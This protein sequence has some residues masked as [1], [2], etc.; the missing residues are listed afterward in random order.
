MSNIEGF[1]ICP[2]IDSKLFYLLVFI[3]CSLM[4]NIIPRVFEPDFE[5]ENDYK[6][7][8]YFDIL[9]NFIGDF[10]AGIMIIVNKFRDNDNSNKL[11]TTQKLKTKKAMKKKFFFYLS[12]IAIID[13]LVQLC[14]S[15]FLFS[16]TI[17]KLMIEKNGQITIK[18]EDLY[19]V[20]LIDI[21]SRYFFS[22]LFLNS[23]FY[24]HHILSIIITCI[25]FIPLTIINIKDIF[26]GITSFKGI[27]LFQHIF[28]TI[29]YSLEDVLNK[30]CLN[31][32]ILRPYE[33]MFY[34][35]VFQIIII[36]PISI[37]AFLAIDQIDYEYFDT[38][39]I[40]YRLSFIIS[41]IFRTWSLITIIELINPNHLSVLKS[42]EFVV[43]FLAVLIFKKSRNKYNYYEINDLVYIFGAICCVISLIGSIIHNEIIIINKCGLLECTDYY[44]AE[45]KGFY[46]GDEDLEIDDQKKRINT[47]DSLLSSSCDE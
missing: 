18:E 20:V 7:K 38:K 17:P 28:M 14:L 25:G 8:S 2:K 35:A 39:F 9:S 46:G 19:F 45:I 43:L 10:L 40:I 6:L 41:N 21:I 23:Y 44:K 34:K 47:Q 37:Y 27:Y 31:Q 13:F 3:S 36:I 12:I 11:T 1:I 29:I 30:I 32:L 5:N 42:S 22:R 15:S 33:L 4:R 16:Y 26:M 24:K